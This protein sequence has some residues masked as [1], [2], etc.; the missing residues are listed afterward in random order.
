M[1]LGAAFRNS[2][3]APAIPNVTIISVTI[4]S[5]GT[6]LFVDILVI[7]LL[8]MGLPAL[9]SYHGSTPYFQFF[10]VTSPMTLPHASHTKLFQPLLLPLFF[11]E[12]Y[13]P[14]PQ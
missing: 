14:N 1:A 8:A 9:G 10:M 13:R 4:A 12:P 3:L 6:I 5:P 7:L 11:Y 2:D